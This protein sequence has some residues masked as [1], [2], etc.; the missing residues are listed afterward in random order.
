MP[1]QQP[2][3]QEAPFYYEAVVLPLGFCAR[4][5]WESS[6]FSFLFNLACTLF[7]VNHC[8]S[9]HIGRSLGPSTYKHGHTHVHSCASAHMHTLALICMHIVHYV[10]MHAC[11]CMQHLP[12]HAHPYAHIGL[13]VVHMYAHPWYAWTYIHTQIRCPFPLKLSHL[14][15]FL[16]FFSFF[17]FYISHFPL[18]L[19][20]IES[21]LKISDS[22]SLWRIWY[23]YWQGLDLCLYQIIEQS[24]APGRGVFITHLSR[25]D[26]KSLQLNPEEAWVTLALSS[27]SGCLCCNNWGTWNWASAASFSRPRASSHI[28]LDLCFLHFLP[29]ISLWG[30]LVF[31]F[32][33]FPQGSRVCVRLKREVFKVFSCG[34][35]KGQG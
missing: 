14:N 32:Q 13:S 3:S 4:A 22:S 31:M 7:L 9:L 25:K 27:D 21:L 6:S 28:R 17:Y 33:H 18:N 16:F 26:M 12:M 19:L 23:F 1:N 30:I 34:G 20:N 5:G 10:R 24:W 2:R 29:N 35:R 8:T 11:A 15:F